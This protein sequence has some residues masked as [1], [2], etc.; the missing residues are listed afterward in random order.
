MKLSNAVKYRSRPELRVFNGNPLAARSSP[1]EG[2]PQLALVWSQPV[3]EKTAKRDR[4]DNRVDSPQDEQSVSGLRRG[5]RWLN[6]NAGG[7]GVLLVI[8]PMLVGAV[9]LAFEG[10][11][12]FKQ[13]E[14]KVSRMD[15]AING[16]GT[17]KG[18]AT[19]VAEIERRHVTARLRK[20]AVAEYGFEEPQVTQVS[21]NPASPPQ[22]LKQI[23]GA[24]S[25]DLQ[26]RVEK[27][28]QDSII[29]TFNGT[30]NTNTYNNLGVAVPKKEGAVKS[31]REI[32][33]QL[34]DIWVV[35]LE[36]PT[37]DSAIIAVG[38]KKKS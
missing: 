22:T 24:V 7:L 26:V 2:R 20:K 25:Y 30:F 21:F 13:L 31:L 5:W 11:S 18:L 12:R 29:F 33:P 23:D 27:V 19:R 6:A 10:Y 1:G 3:S 4:R 32:F 34:P 9:W 15:E 28:T 38:V 37:P 36:L 35:I 14:E 17:K 16:K 8:V